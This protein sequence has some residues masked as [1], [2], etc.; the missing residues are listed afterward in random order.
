M[1]SRQEQGCGEGLSRHKN[2]L[3]EVLA[4]YRSVLAEPGGW[5]LP[6]A[7]L[8]CT[9]GHLGISMNQRAGAVHLTI[10]DR[11]WTDW[12][13]QVIPGASKHILWKRRNQNIVKIYVCLGRELHL[14]S[15][16]IA[17]SDKENDFQNSF[18]SL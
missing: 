7:L 10:T 1:A 11:S 4:E 6:I 3:L 18:W 15:Y 5:K 12:N 13:S 14:S 9:F 17:L 2:V 8:M 16:V